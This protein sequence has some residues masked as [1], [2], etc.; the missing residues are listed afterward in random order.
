VHDVGN[1]RILIALHGN[2]NTLPR[3][4][5]IGARGP[6][7]RLRTVTDH[8]LDTIRHKE[9]ICPDLLR[10]VSFQEEIWRAGNS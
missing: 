10:V 4:P 3:W 9:Y 6:K 1:G 7:W 2:V 8:L 5:K